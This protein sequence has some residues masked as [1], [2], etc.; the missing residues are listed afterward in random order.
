MANGYGY[1]R[2]GYMPRQEGWGFFNP[3]MRSPDIAGGISAL[4]DMIGQ[5]QTMEQQ[6]Q[7]RA[8]Q[9]RMA[10]EEMALNWFKALQPDPQTQWQAQDEYMRT[11]LAP[12]A[13]KR[14]RMTGEIEPPETQEE[15]LRRIEGEATA[16]ARGTAAGK[17]PEITD[18]QFGLDT[19]LMKNTLSA[20]EGEL[21]RIIRLHERV[22]EPTAK[23]RLSNSLSNLDATA[24]QLRA[25]QAQMSSGQPLSPQI[26][27][28]I[29]QIAGD[30]TG[31]K[32]GKYTGQTGRPTPQQQAIPP[33][34]PTATNPQTG[35][36]V[37]YVNGKWIK[38]Q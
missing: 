31:V 10:E 22:E 20:V 16:R 12:E 23:N 15:R 9:Q 11:N 28:R 35:E 36:K 14:W 37:A 34:A 38:I 33:N 17:P 2:Y 32:A 21:D 6:A 8:F 27:N 18:K 13:Y 7:Q 24:Q 5:R 29:K 30:M 1:G 19:T 4:T 3:W 26:R 25:I